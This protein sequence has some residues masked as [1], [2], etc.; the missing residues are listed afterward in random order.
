MATSS[1][2]VRERRVRGEMKEGLTSAS[3]PGTLN[4][5]KI[6]NFVETW[7][8]LKVTFSTSKNL[9]KNTRR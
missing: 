5:F 9:D 8:A 6:L 1:A 4:E 2:R 3:L 7:F